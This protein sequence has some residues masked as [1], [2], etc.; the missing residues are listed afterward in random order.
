MSFK[1]FRFIAETNIFLPNEKLVLFQMASFQ[2]EQTKRCNPSP[3]KIAFYTQLSAYQ[4][5]SILKK[6]EKKQIIERSQHGWTF[7]FPDQQSPEQIPD[8]WWPSSFAI[9]ALIQANPN[10]H[11]DMK[12]AVYDFINFCNQN[13][14][15]IRPDRLDA[16]FVRNISHLLEY[17]KEGHAQIA[18]DPSRQERDSILSGFIGRETS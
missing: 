10:H 7:N 13:G 9:D 17:R 4:V 12:E 18:N 6:L 15:S 11:F 1:T 2:N 5:R 14:H 3:E 16:A 8:D